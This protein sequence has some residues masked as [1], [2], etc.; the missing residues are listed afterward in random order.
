MNGQIEVQ[1]ESDKEQEGKV[2]C[3]YESEC[4]EVGGVKGGFPKWV[5]SAVS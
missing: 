5:V 3:V 4:Q 1:L 2:Q